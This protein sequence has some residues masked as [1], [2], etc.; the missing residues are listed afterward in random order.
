MKNSLGK[1][2]ST[3]RKEHKWTQIE[4]AKQL[5]VNTKNV[6]RWE[7]NEN[8]PNI[9]MA[10][11]IAEVLTM[12]LDYLATGNKQSEADVGFNRKL[13]KL[14]AKQIEAVRVIVEGL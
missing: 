5:K 3:A 14:K 11:K 12:S 2:I 13:N 10:V 8:Q 1:R 7:K 6:M 9:E 4:L